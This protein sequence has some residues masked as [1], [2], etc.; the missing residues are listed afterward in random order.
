MFYSEGD[1]LGIISS[2]ASTVTLWN[3]YNK[4][5]TIVDAGLRD[6][7]TCLAWSKVCT[8]QS[9]VTGILPLVT[10]STLTVILPIVTKHLD[11][12]LMLR[13]QDVWFFIKG[14]LLCDVCRP[15]KNSSNPLALFWNNT[16]LFYWLPIFFLKWPT[17]WRKKNQDDNGWL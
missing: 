5:K 1:L 8:S 10:W 9:T 16:C 3:T 15:E 6:S 4:K 2:N 14:W 17:F 13:F 11:Q 7:L 12:I